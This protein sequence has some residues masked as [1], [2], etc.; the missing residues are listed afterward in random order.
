MLYISNKSKYC[1]LRKD[2]KNKHVLLLENL[3]LS[4]KNNT[5]LIIKGKNGS[6][7]TSLLNNLTFNKIRFETIDLNL[8]NFFGK[9]NLLNYFY[10]NLNINIEFRNISVYFNNLSFGYK[11]FYTIFLNTIIKK[12]IFLFDEPFNGLDKYFLTHINRLFIYIYSMN[13]IQIKSYHNKIKITK[14]STIFLD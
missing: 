12:K 5:I 1:L 7:K 14:Y 3:N 8:I 4:I 13:T 9:I 10:N 11:K 2:L 6:G